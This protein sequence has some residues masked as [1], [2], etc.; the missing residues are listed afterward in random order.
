[1]F[2]V[3]SSWRKRRQAIATDQVTMAQIVNHAGELYGDDGRKE[4]A[5]RGCR[6]EL[7]ESGHK[8]E[9]RTGQEFCHELSG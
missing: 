1:M 7:D 5:G 8:V 2:L 3:K 9:L 6:V 4:L